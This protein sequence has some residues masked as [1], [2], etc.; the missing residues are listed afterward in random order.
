MTTLLRTPGELFDLS[1]PVAVVTGA[2]SGLGDPCPRNPKS[3]AT[4]PSGK[5]VGADP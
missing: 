2:S 4:F 3:T 1:G 5:H